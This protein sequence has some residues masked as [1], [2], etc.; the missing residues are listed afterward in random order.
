MNCKKI[1][2]YLSLAIDGRRHPGR[3]E[4]ISEHLKNCPSCRSW[5][6][7]QQEI[8]EYLSEVPGDT[9]SPYFSNRLRQRIRSGRS[10]RAYS[11]PVFPSFRRLVITSVMLMVFLLAVFAGL[12]LGTRGP[13][14]IESER[15]A[16]FVR[17]LE[18]NMFADLPSESFGAVYTSLL[19]E[20]ER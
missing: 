20:G 4:C 10:S 9:L 7:Q 13:F 2:K 8:S 19:Q 11:L 12:R 1:R 18:L 3:Q 5:Q 15:E 14:S 16:V 6:E 17:T